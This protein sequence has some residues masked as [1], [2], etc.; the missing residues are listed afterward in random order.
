MKLSN[1]QIQDLYTFT[2]KHYVEWYDVQLELVDHLANGIEAQW[3]ENPK[4]T[5]EDA[6]QLEF[7]KF[8]ICG[9]SDVIAK[10]TNALNKEYWLLIWHGFKDYFKLP[11][12]II[13]VFLIWVYF[14]AF[15]FLMEYNI[16]LVMVP[17]LTLLF[18]LPW[19]TFIKNFRTVKRQKQQTAKKW[20]FEQTLSQLGGLVHVMNIALY[21]EIIYQNQIPWSFWPS[22]IFS[23]FVVSFLVLLYVAIF[24]VTPR[25]RKQMEKLYPEYK[26][27]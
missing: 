25:L 2:Q 18:G 5:F 11:K 27:T 15:V 26:F 14:Q 13:T 23:I 22:L 7:K 3:N 24:E 17:T 1:A 9:F 19:Y 16:N 4:L 6:L 8:G 21:L 10:K 20:L 12:L